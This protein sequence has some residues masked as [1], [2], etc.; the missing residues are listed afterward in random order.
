[1][2][3]R[4][5][6]DVVV[7]GGGYSGI[8]AAWSLRNRGHSVTVLEARDRVGGR[9]W[10][11]H[12]P[13]GGWVDNG[14]QWIGP[15]MTKILELA[16]EVGVATF[17]TYE[18]GNSI[19]VYDGKR[20]VYGAENAHSLGIPVPEADLRDF[21][22]AVMEIDKLSGEIPPHAPWEAP[23][24]R[25][26]DYQTVESWMEQNL[27]TDGAKFA[28]RSVVAG[29]FA[30]EACDLSFLHL[31]FYVAAAGGIEALEESS[32]VWRFDGGAQE[33]PNRLAERLGMRISLDAAVR[34][35]DQTGDTVIVETDAGSHAARR[36]I[37]AISPALAARIDYRPSLPASRDQYMQRAPLGSVIKCHAVYP[38]PFWRQDGLNGQVVSEEDVNSVFDNSP[39][40]GNPG[41]LVGF[42]EGEAARRWADR[43]EADVRRKMLD[44]F[45]EHFG[46]RAR[47]PS[48]FYYANWAMQAWSRGCYCGV[49]TPG[50]WTNYRDAVRT[51][52]GRVHWAGTEA[53]TKWVQYM[54]GAVRSGQ[55]AAAEVHD[56]LAS[57]P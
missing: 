34:A 50:T 30:V 57:T 7:I 46:D 19:L 44:T 2:L 16:R 11:E 22:T 23:R 53:A 54:E 49:P 29:Y 14:G 40:G 47:Q 15:G 51:P 20:N 41:I 31:L 6:D 32:L 37:V 28:L 12:V 1:V 17:P 9:A 38:T 8:A 36:V 52:V 56:A 43:S 27:A 24:A 25:E 10:T 55:R 13:G 35:I 45:A 3:A 18:D 26:F 21:M 4:Q 42:I 5:V 33:I 39:P 48:G